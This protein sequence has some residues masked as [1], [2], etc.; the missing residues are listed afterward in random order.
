MRCMNKTAASTTPT[1]MA[2]VR[3]TSTVNANVKSSTTRSP[4]GARIRCRKR[5][6]SLMFEA[7]MSS[8]AATSRRH[9]CWLRCGQSLRWPACRRKPRRPNWRRP[10]RS[11]RRSA[12]HPIRD[13]RAHQALDARE[14][15]DRESGR[16]QRAYGVPIEVRLGRRQIER[17]GCERGN[18]DDEQE[19][20]QSRRPT[21]HRAQKRD[22]ADRHRDGDWI[23]VTEAVR[24]GALPA[25]ISSRP[26]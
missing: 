17:R 8:T 9:G 26:P 15:C 25:A 18:Y 7:T 23:Q 16:Y 3:S 5:T 1:S 22:A 4:S 6:I 20:G 11:V 10:V 24:V 12:G 19:G 2:T 21:A 14:E 13:D